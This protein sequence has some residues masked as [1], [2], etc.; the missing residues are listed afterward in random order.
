MIWYRPERRE[1]EN[2]FTGTER[3]AAKK[4]S[5]GGARENASGA[6]LTRP[7]ACKVRAVRAASRKISCV[8]APAGAGP[9]Q[10]ASHGPGDTVTWTSP[11]GDG[12]LS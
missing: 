12:V 11:C 4:R 9:A 2:V 8:A 6:A 10:C 3:T 5:D 7:G 1:G